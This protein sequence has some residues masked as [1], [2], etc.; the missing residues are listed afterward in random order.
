MSPT[1]PP[2]FPYY[3]ALCD[4][5]FAERAKFQEHNKGWDH[6]ALVTKRAYESKGWRPVFASKEVL[7]AAKVPFKFD[8]V[9]FSDVDHQDGTSRLDRFGR[10]HFRPY[11]PNA[12][13]DAITEWVS[14]P[15]SGPRKKMDL[16]DYLRTMF[17]EV[18]WEQ[19]ERDELNRAVAAQSGVKIG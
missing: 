7:E 8:A 3:C 14:L 6:R 12:V 4:A 15:S 9:P 18:N 2:T 11:V 10:G 1:A 13:A 16:G 19:L 5:R 17:K